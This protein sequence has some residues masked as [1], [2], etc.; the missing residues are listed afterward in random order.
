VTFELCLS[1][2]L[3]NAV[4]NWIIRKQ[5]DPEGVFYK[6]PS[7]GT[8]PPEC[9]WI[10]DGVG[11]EPSPN[12]HSVSKDVEHEL[13]TRLTNLE[14]LST[15][16]LCEQYEAHCKATVLKKIY[17]ALW[18]ELPK[19]TQEA[20]KEASKKK[21]KPVTQKRITQKITIVVQVGLQPPQGR[22]AQSFNMMVTFN[23]LVLHLKESIAN[24]VIKETGKEMELIFNGHKILSKLAN[25]DKLGIEKGSTIVVL[26]VKSQVPGK[27]LQ[28][29][30]GTG[31]K[32][33]KSTLLPI[34]QES[35]SDI[36][37]EE[38]KDRSSTV[39]NKQRKSC[40]IS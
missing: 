7:K 39:S 29:I 26:G 34:L 35:R 28:K 15:L 13:K 2:S 3:D 4:R 37:Q 19:E 8:L 1:P 30:G 9:D 23:T 31:M 10:L 6:A 5:K 14:L 33:K 38:E 36:F 18:R 20:A 21:P 32:P 22:T 17:M 27:G 25:I 16:D 12:V 11:Q 40:V 24:Q